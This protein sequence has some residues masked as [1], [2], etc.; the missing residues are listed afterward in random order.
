VVTLIGEGVISAKGGDAVSS[1]EYG[2]GGGGGRIAIYAGDM[3][4]FHPENVIVD[5]G[6]GSQSGQPGTI[7]LR[8]L[9]A[10]YVLFHSPDGLLY[11]PV[12]YVDVSFHTAIRSSTFTRDDI[13]VIGPE[14]VIETDP[15]VLQGGGI[16]RIY[17]PSQST[18]GQYHVYV[19]PHIED[20]SGKEMDQDTDSIEGEDPDDV[21]DAGFAIKTTSTDNNVNDP[22]IAVDNGYDTDEDMV[23]AVTAPGVLGNDSDIDSSSLQAFLV[24]DVSNGTLTLNPDGS[25]NYN[26]HNNF[27]GADAF[28]YKASDGINESNTAKVIITVNS[29]ND[30]P[31]ANVAGPYTSEEG[32]PITFDASLSSDIDMDELQ[33][34]WDFNNDGIWDT[35]YSVE[36]RATY[37]WNDDYSGVI[38]VEVSDGKLADGATASVTVIDVSPQFSLTVTPSPSNEGEVVTLEYNIFDP[39]HDGYT[40]TKID[41]GDDIADNSST[42]IYTDNGA[43]TITSTFTE[44]NGGATVRT[45]SVIQNI[46]NI[47]PTVYAGQN[48]TADEGATVSFSGGFSDP[49]ADDHTVEWNFGDGNTLL[50]NLTTTHTYG[51]NGVYTVTLTITDDDGGVGTDTLTVTVHNV[52]PTVAN[53]MNDNLSNGEIALSVGF[54]D[55]GWL[56]SH[57]GIFDFGDGAEAPDH[58]AEE[59][60]KPDATGT[61]TGT[62]NYSDEGR[63]T[64]SLVVEDDDGGRSEPAS[65]EVL[66]DKT[67]PVITVSEPKAKYHYNAHDIKIGFEVKDPISNEIS[68]GVVEES[69]VATLNGEV[70]ENGQVIDLSELEDGT[71]TF[72]V[73]AS[74]FAGNEVEEE[75]V[76]EVGVGSVPA[77]LNLTPH[78]WRLSWLNPFDDFGRKGFKSQHGKKKRITAY[79]SLENVEVETTIPTFAAPELKVGKGYGDFVVVEVI[80]AQDNKRG[81]H[82]EIRS[83]TLKYVG[84]GELDIL[85]FSGNRTWDFFGV[86]EGDAIMIDTG[87]GEHLGS[88]TVL[89]YYKYGSPL[90]SAAD[91]IPETILLNDRV[92]IIE[93]SAE[94]IT[95]NPS[96]LG[97]S[98]VIAERPI[99]IVREGRHHVWL[100]NLAEPERITLKVGNQT[101]FEDEPY[102]IHWHDRFS[103]EEDGEVQ[104]MGIYAH[105]KA[106]ML[107][108]IR[109][110]LQEEAKIYLD[111]ALAFTIPPDINLLVLKVQFNRFDAIS[112][113]P[114]EV[115]ERGGDWDVTTY[116]R[117][118]L[119]TKHKHSMKH[120]TITDLDDPKK[121][122]LIVGDTVIFDD[123]PFPIRWRD[124][125][126]IVDGERQDMSIYTC[127]SSRRKK[128][129]SIRLKRLTRDAKLY[130]DGEL[131]LLISPPPDVKVSII[132][133]LELDGDPE[134]FDGSFSGIDKIGL[135]GKIPYNYD[136]DRTY[137]QINTSGSPK[138]VVGDSFG[139]FE[140][141]SVT[142]GYDDYRITTLLFRYDGRTKKEVKVY[143][144]AHGRHFIGSYVAYPGEIF[145]V[146]V[147]E[148]EGDKVYL[149]IKHKRRSFRLAGRHAAEVGD[150]YLGCTVIDTAKEPQGPPHYIDLTL[151][152]K[153]GA[154]PIFITAYDG[155]WQ[156]VINTYKADPASVPSFT[157]DGRQLRRGHIGGE[158]VLEY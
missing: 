149:Q 30:A 85:A 45:V 67:P 26:P 11:Q 117:V 65:I 29:V 101:I 154:E 134:T 12:G 145:L 146:D 152:Y 60:E 78:T 153:G 17:F 47:A 105:K 122:R 79:I 104:M 140:V 39:G 14:G 70:V 127:G 71:Y 116:G 74:D 107:H 2:G 144:D 40:L 51:D 123:Q 103:L 93:R 61:I 43:Y 35:D 112:S 95:K 59:N 62:H 158:L 128:H 125:Y 9:E 19:G 111:G 64:V 91:I 52:V 147:S 141:V 90:Y 157:I 109:H 139:D 36:P 58:L 80:A 102:P 98:R 92:P 15:P 126:F 63:H 115:L 1:N 94:V 110:N 137:Q 97:Q 21:Y 81:K 23:L 124:R 135:K 76:F 88:Y 54:A 33:Y 106:D 72:K 108:V 41:W 143:E 13:R 37:A 86:K 82:K 121:V 156:Y 53:L 83:V 69:V 28:T 66:I 24:D 138:L 136:I 57:S 151:E 96:Q 77:I 100:T 22:P 4:G 56:D 130:L 84:T 133:D 148:V 73:V 99:T 150:S 119:Q 132:G 8:P 5:G 129:L 89:S 18:E 87:E 46:S 25:F 10:P 3:S 38:V 32:T 55:R 114:K 27:N 142:E 155:Y 42:H 7:Y 120:I 31:V 49:G 48:R 113:L 75:V 50:G 6:S 44:D 118:R 20:L 131:V 68:S 34:R 16:W